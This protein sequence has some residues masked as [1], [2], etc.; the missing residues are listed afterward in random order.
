V[1]CVGVGVVAGG[2][3]GGDDVAVV[4]GAV[5]VAVAAAVAVVVLL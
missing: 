3:C 5:D 1:L 2:G 4:D